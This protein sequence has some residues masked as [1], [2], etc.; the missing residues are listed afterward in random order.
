MTVNRIWTSKYN[1]WKTGVRIISLTMNVIFI[2]IITIA[3]RENV[4]FVGAMHHKPGMMVLYDISA[5][6]GVLFLKRHCKH[7]P[8]MQNN[9]DW[10]LNCIQFLKTKYLIYVSKL[11]RCLYLSWLFYHEERDICPLSSFGCIWTYH[12]FYVWACLVHL[13]H[14]T[15]IR[16]IRFTVL[17]FPESIQFRLSE[18]ASHGLI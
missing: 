8:W 17:L 13:Q 14:E 16:S 3:L 1:A 6:I 10:G 9:I 7:L 12:M 4:Y 18:T 2:Y 5:G 15:S 11:F